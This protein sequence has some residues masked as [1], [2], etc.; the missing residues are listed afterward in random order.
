MQDINPADVFGFSAWELSDFK[1]NPTKNEKK[2]RFGNSHTASFWDN[3]SFL[4]EILTPTAAPAVYQ[5]IYYGKGCK[6]RWKGCAEK[7]LAELGPITQMADSITWWQSTCLWS[8]IENKKNRVCY[9]QTRTRI[10]QPRW[11]LTRLFLVVKIDEQ[12][13][14]PYRQQRND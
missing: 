14:K 1:M 13:A 12:V 11:W 10:V 8:N 2:K 3:G 9:Q 6:S 4:Q 5:N 7:T